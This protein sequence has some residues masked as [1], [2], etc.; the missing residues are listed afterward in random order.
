MP[1]ELADLRI[2]A[3]WILPMSARG[4]PLGAHSLLVRDGRIAA[5]L[6]RAEAER[7]FA[8]TVVA[9]RGT[10]LLLPGLI[11]SH[12]HAPLVALAGLLREDPPVAWGGCASADAR[13]A[14]A[15]FAADTLPLAIEAMLRAG[16]TCFADQY[17][18]ADAAARAAVECGMRAVVAAPIAEFATPAGGTLADHLAAALALHD[19]YRDHPSVTTAFAPVDLARTTDGALARVKTLADELDTTISLHLHESAAEI[20]DSLARHGLRPI[21]RLQR[22]GL[23]TPSLHAIHLTHVDA[24]D[25][26]L[27]VETGIAATVCASSNLRLGNGLPDAARLAASGLR[28]GLGTDGGA[29]NNDLDLWHEVRLNAL[30]GRHALDAADGPTLGAAEVLALATR[31]S[32]AALGLAHEIGT[33]ETGKW[34]DV[35]CLDVAAS[36]APDAAALIEQ[37]VFHGGRDIVSDVW[38]AGRHLLAGFRPTRLDG[39]EARARARR[40]TDR[41]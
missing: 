40:W 38:V 5:V 25:L 18:F 13:L 7:R 11:D 24:D 12:T 27:A 21:G 2:D 10:H 30:S 22:L 3:R 14:C 26:R 6:P 41:L 9:D 19:E 23:L 17:W 16:V 39:D 36:A 15:Q 29:A 37:L 35:C 33:L 4:A 1:K 20:G 8:P 32:A 28:L 31:G 34:A